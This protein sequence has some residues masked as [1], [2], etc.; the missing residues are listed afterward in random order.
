MSR[1]SQVRGPL[2][3]ALLEET[4][5]DCLRR[6]AAQHG[7]REAL[8]S[9][10]QDVRLTYAQLDAEVDRV[11]RALIAAGLQV[12]DRVGIW[13]PNCAEWTVIQ[14]A[15]ARAG[16][17]LVNVNP[18]YRTSELVY[19]LNQ[20]GCRM[21]LAARAFKT[22]D[23]AA[24]IDEVRDELRT[25]ER[26]FFL[27]EDSWEDADVA[28]PQLAPTD[29]INIQYTSGTTGAP[30]GA[31]LSHRNILTNG[32]LVGEACRYTPEDRVCIP[33]PFYH[34][35][36][37]VMGNLGALTHAATMVIP[38]PA[39]D[40]AAT[41]AAVAQER[42]TS[43]YGVPTMFIAELDHPGFGDYDLTSLRTGIM[44]GSPCPVEVM[45]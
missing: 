2:E 39:F 1:L 33:V 30:K 10:H 31:T 29:A 7:E 28:L 32:F 13:S 4:I 5:G 37:M 6:I 15:T 24:M 23:Y 14:L 21:L 3:P 17:I 45:K 8:V 26:V 43:L 36:G 38:A 35:F 11:A 41:L 27:G 42:C 9:C 19:A 12:G 34:C 16:I 25:V 20:S 18:A 44:A 22:S 40:P